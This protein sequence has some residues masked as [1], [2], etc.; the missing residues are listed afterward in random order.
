MK[1]YATLKDVAKLAGTTAATV[2][3]VLN[4]KEGRYISDETRRKVLEAAKQLEYVKS[5]GASSL[6]G[7]S[8]KL[9]A[10]LIPQFENQFFTRIVVASE[11]VFVKHGYDLIICNTFDKPEREKAIL[12]RMI[13]QR[14]D[15]II[16]TPTRMGTE[17]TKL[18]R[19]VGMKMV[20]VDRPLPG[21]K[22]FFWVATNNYGCGFVGA[23]YL[24]SKGHR[25]VAYI[26]W[27]S[28]IQDLEARKR[29]FFDAADSYGI[30]HDSLVVAE[31]GFSAE[32][33]CRLTSE[34]LEKHPD[35]TAIFYGFNIQ[36]L[37][38]VK[39]LSQRGISIPEELSVM[40]IGSPEWIMAGKNDFTHVD[41]NDIELG[42][43]AANLLLSQI[44]QEDEVPFQHIIQDCT[45]IEGS[46][47]RDIR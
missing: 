41:M 39:C 43:K 32:E 42:R 1:R 29:A 26:G 5:I 23:H 8:R 9:I 44:Q 13:Q 33:G 3:Y 46:S 45:L 28:G 11:E 20:V 12:N 31:G 21:V 10:I 27:E 14:V 4:E 19:K 37:G 34:V 30:A 35:V 36:A 47:V 17:N 40:I 6:K 2:S 18:L 16:L 15:G 24:F 22:D 25:K 38:G 7:K